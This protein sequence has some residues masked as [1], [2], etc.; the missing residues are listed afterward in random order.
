MDREEVLEDILEKT[1]TLPQ[2][3]V[4]TR[5]VCWLV[6]LC[7]LFGEGGCGRPFLVIER[8]QPQPRPALIQSKPTTHSKSLDLNPDPLQSHTNLPPTA[9]VLYGHL[10]PLQ[11]ER[12][13]RRD[14]EGRP[15]R[16]RLQGG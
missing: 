12:A 4:H 5:S 3:Q 13:P 15:P 14:E 7:C 6:G 1:L 8:S 9:K 10:L 11:Q 2:I 16:P